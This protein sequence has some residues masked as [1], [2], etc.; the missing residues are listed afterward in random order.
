[1]VQP[2]LRPCR[3]A[4]H[5]LREDFYCADIPLLITP[6]LA[7]GSMMLSP[8]CQRLGDRVADTVVIEANSIQKNELVA[9][10]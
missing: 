10:E 4:Q 2:S 8:N 5:V 9:I 3:L 6:L 1:V 7:A